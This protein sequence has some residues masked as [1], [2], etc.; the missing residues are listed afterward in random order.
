MGFYGVLR[1]LAR[2]YRAKQFPALTVANIGAIDITNVQRCGEYYR[3]KPPPY[4]VVQRRR[5]E[6]DKDA[7]LC[8][9]VLCVGV[10]VGGK[11][12]LL[13]QWHKGP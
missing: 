7:Y 2:L 12:I 10:G 4:R 3:H 9:H 11:A 8:A 5:A 13:L 1:G 6:P